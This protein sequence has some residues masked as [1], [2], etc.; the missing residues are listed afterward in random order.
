MFH[1][2]LA[3]IRDRPGRWMTVDAHG[4]QIGDTDPVLSAL[5]SSRD[6]K[7]VVTATEDRTAR[8]WDATNGRAVRI[9]W[10][11]VPVP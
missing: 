11:P 6:G 5:F 9:L 1:H 8:I 10:L 3:L 2:A 4:R 7:L